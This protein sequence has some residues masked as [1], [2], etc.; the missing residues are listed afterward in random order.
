MQ[1]DNL[2]GIKESEDM[3][4]IPYLP[5]VNMSPKK[6]QGLYGKSAFI[7]NIQTNSYTCPNKEVLG[8]I[9][10][11]QQRGKEYYQYGNQ[12]A[13]ENCPIK[14]R[15]TDK[16]MRIVSRWEHEEY[17]ERATKRIQENPEKMGER[18]G[19]VEHP[20][21]TIKTQILVNGFFVRGKEKV[22]AEASL[23]HFAYNLKRVLNIVSFDKLMSAIAARVEA[24]K[25]RITS[26]THMRATRGSFEAIIHLGHQVPRFFILIKTTKKAAEGPISA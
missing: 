4:M 22:Q 8:K 2:L 21:G 16:K 20:Y 25:S 14:S 24:K 9:R 23:A 15:C 5:T 26:Y 18:K 17:Q 1:T 10:T 19:I 11:T 6:R 3:N 13:C 7:Y 12:S